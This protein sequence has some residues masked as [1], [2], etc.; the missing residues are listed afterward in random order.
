MNDSCPASHNHKSLLFGE[1][2]LSV[3]SSGNFLSKSPKRSSGAAIN[4]ATVSNGG[5]SG[6]IGWLRVGT[7]ILVRL[8]DFAIDSES[9][10]G[11]AF[12]SAGRSDSSSSLI[13]W[14]RSNIRERRVGSK[15]ALVDGR[16]WNLLSLS[17]T[18]IRSQ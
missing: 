6:A 11:I 9:T 16:S 18:C 17:L 7:N 13:C 8:K 5:L 14:L 1:S 15:S 10:L 4:P 3:E 12:S 2:A